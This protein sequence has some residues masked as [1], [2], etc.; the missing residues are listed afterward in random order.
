MWQEDTLQQCI[1]VV[2]GRLVRA[3]DW[4]LEE[5]LGPW[6][7]TAEGAEAFGSSIEPNEDLR[8]GAEFTEAHYAMLQRLDLESCAS[9]LTLFGMRYIR[10]ADAIE[11]GGDQ[12]PIQLPT[13]RS[14]QPVLYLDHFSLTS[15][16]A[17]D[18]EEVLPRSPAGNEPNAMR[19][20]GP[21][22]EARAIIAA[23]LELLENA[24]FRLHVA[25]LDANSGGKLAT[26]LQKPPWVQQGVQNLASCNL[27]KVSPSSFI[28]WAKDL[29]G[30]MVSL[31]RRC[32]RANAQYYSVSAAA[33]AALSR[34]RMGPKPRRAASYTPLLRSSPVGEEDAADAGAE[35]ELSSP[36]PE[37]MRR[38]RLARFGL[39]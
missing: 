18:G 3:A 30:V 15:R 10:L 5:F 32:Y 23:I 1:G 22:Q 24:D 13:T 6:L 31:D 35:G 11:D 2:G 39:R 29:V 12:V 8:E 37:E 17:P 4:P 14:G 34:K 26:W 38:R 28:S 7:W 27:A 36:S 20:K 16:V 19:R 9:V 21:T 25:E 33:A